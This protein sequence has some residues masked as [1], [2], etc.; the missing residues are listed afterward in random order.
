L[1]GNLRFGENEL[2]DREGKWC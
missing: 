1:D 2:K